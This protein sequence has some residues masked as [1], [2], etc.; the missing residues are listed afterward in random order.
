MTSALQV[1]L[2]GRSVLLTGATSVLGEAFARA[3][4]ASGARV[5]LIAR[6]QDRLVA[7]AEELGASAVVADLEDV[8]SLAAAVAHVRAEIG[9]LD[10]LINAAARGA[11]AAGAESEPAEQ[12]VGT[13]TVNVT[14]PMVLAQLVYGDMR[15]LGRG[16]IVNIGSIVGEV[17]VGRFPQASYAASKGAMHAL[18]R[19]LAAQWSRH[20]IRVNCLAP[21]FF[22]SEMTESLFES[23]KAEEWIRR[24]EML[25]RHAE[26]ADLVGAL[27][28]L[29]SDASSTMTGQVLVVDNGWTA[30]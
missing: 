16:C 8:G 11:S 15:A 19:E 21:G 28:F 25:P 20:G 1:D 12:I 6:R 4:V 22:R 14:A 10:T 18:T 30:R 13:L 27:L 3:L 29:V 17:G 2:S 7:L 24:G 9:P 5:G 23:P 26:A